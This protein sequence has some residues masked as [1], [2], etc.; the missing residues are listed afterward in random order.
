MQRR[1]FAD[2]VAKFEVAVGPVPLRTLPPLDAPGLDLGR[3]GDQRGPQRGPGVPLNEVL[4][5]RPDLQR[6]NTS[7]GGKSGPQPQPPWRP[8]RGDPNPTTSFLESIGF[9]PTKFKHG[10]PVHGPSHAQG[11]VD[12]ELEGGEYVI[13]KAAMQAMQA[14]GAVERRNQSIRK[15]NEEVNKDRKAE[16]FKLF[17]IGDNGRFVHGRGGRILY[18]GEHRKAVRKPVP[19]R[20][21]EPGSRPIDRGDA[22]HFA[23]QERLSRR[24]KTRSGRTIRGGGGGGGGAGVGRRAGDHLIN[25]GPNPGAVGARKSSGKP[26]TWEQA[27]DGVSGASIRQRRHVATLRR[28]HETEGQP[29][30]RFGLPATGGFGPSLKGMMAR[31]ELMQIADATRPPLSPATKWR[32]YV[33]ALERKAIKGDPIARKKLMEIEARARARRKNIGLQRPR[34]PA[35]GRAKG[36]VVYAAAGGSIF[37]PKGTDT[38]P[39]MLTP[40]EFVI[41]KD[42]VNAVGADTLERINSMGGGGAPVNAS[43]GGLINYLKDG[44][45]VKGKKEKEI[46][47]LRAIIQQEGQPP[48]PPAPYQGPVSSPTPGTPLMNPLASEL[49]QATP[50]VRVEWARARLAELEDSRKPPVS[51]GLK[52]FRERMRLMR[53]AEHGTPGERATA[54]QELAMTPPTSQREI[55]LGTEY[56]D[57]KHGTPIA[58]LPG[59]KA[60]AGTRQQREPKNLAKLKEYRNKIQGSLVTHFGRWDSEAGLLSAAW[61]DEKG[62]IQDPYKVVAPWV[63]KWGGAAFDAA[64]ED[65]DALTDKINAALDARYAADEK[66]RDEKIKGKEIEGIEA[67]ARPGLFIR[68]ADGRGPLIKDRSRRGRGRFGVT[69][70]QFRGS[71]TTA[72]DHLQA[73]GTVDPSTG[74]KKGRFDKISSVRA[75][76]A[77]REDVAAKARTAKLSKSQYKMLE[78]DEWKERARLAGV[79]AGA[80]KGEIISAESQK[81]FIAKGSSGD[82]LI[83]ISDSMRAQ[84]NSD[85]FPEFDG[86]EAR[87]RPPGSIARPSRKGSGIASGGPFINISTL[88]P[89]IVTQEMW[90]KMVELSSI[91]SRAEETVVRDSRYVDAF[92]KPGGPGTYVSKQ[93][94]MTAYAE[95][96]LK[97]QQRTRFRTQKGTGKRIAIGGK[98]DRASK[99]VQSIRGPKNLRPGS[100]A[101]TRSLDK[102]RRGAAKAR[103]RNSKRIAGINKIRHKGGLLPLK[104]EDLNEFG[105]PIGGWK[106]ALTTGSLEA[107]RRQSREDQASGAFRMKRGGYIHGYNTG[108]NVDS[109]QASL[110]PGEFVMR[111]DSVRKYGEKFMNDVNLQKLNRGGGVGASAGGGSKKVVQ[112]SDMER[113]AKLAGESILNAFTKGSQMVGD[114]I[115]QALAPENLAAQIGD[116]VGQKMQESISATKIELNTTGSMDVRLSGDTATGDI[117][118]KMQGAVKDAVAGALSRRTNADGSL[119][120]ADIHNNGLA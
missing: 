102:R 48:W 7:K 86:K 113:G 65:V 29:S 95:A 10:G 4:L 66:R 6:L 71:G 60:S 34:K 32:R 69:G 88:D 82:A 93:A 77:R 35:P 76:K 44:G 100:P 62:M 70:S 52:R 20:V 104:D 22:I 103:A 59:M 68:R 46:R 58:S 45:E 12:A 120:D 17:Q 9:D 47:R 27:G 89:E 15:R 3:L 92:G 90:D 54:R 56:G 16:G 25:M 23:D 99:E 118:R 51:K 80:T 105:A 75:E 87:N 101:H 39:A 21:I 8:K 72:F 2:A 67:G 43:R 110:T 30:S 79:P 19:K 119:K 40:G 81:E 18:E 94:W 96:E 26:W 13:P 107:P 117:A 109:V 115:R 1:R 97:R 36:G 98:Q 116:V 112:S 37:K 57:P 38:V 64:L 63:V 31:K 73:A 91:L 111:R 14:G 83:R 55:L 33:A 78:K 108:G 85:L 49:L 42:A 50:G 61:D 74:L 24:R 84:A 53:L 114:A 106:N 41:R 11:G 5:R 28:T